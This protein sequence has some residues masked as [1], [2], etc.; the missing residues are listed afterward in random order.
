MIPASLL[1]HLWQSTLFAVAVGLLTLALRK[2]PA[3]VRYWLWFAASCKFLVPFSLLVTIGSLFDRRAGPVNS[4]L[5]LSAVMDQIGRPFA[6]EAP[7]LLATV[8]RTVSWGPVILFGAWLC[9]F[10]IVVFAWARQWQRVRT[11]VRT[12]SPLHLDLSIHAVSSR[13]HL[14][15]GVFGIFRPVL[16]MPEGIT[17]R[18]TPAQW[19][20]ILTHEL[21][22]VR[23]RDNL[24]AAIHMAIEAIFWFHPLV[25][26]IGKRLIDER[27]RACDEEVLLAA[28]D[29]EVYAEGLLNVCRI[30]LE[31]PLACVSGVTGSNLRKRVSAIMTQRQADKL[32]SGRKLLLAAAGLVAIGGPILFGLADAP[33]G[34]AQ[35]Q[36]AVGSR[37]VFDA[38]SI[39]PNTTTNSPGWTRFEPAGINIQR[40]S[41][42]SLISTAYRIPG[43]LVSADPR[44][45][46]LFAA[47]YDIIAKAEHEV[48]KDQLAL[49]LQTLLADR[50]KLT[51]HREN[52]LQPVYKL[53]IA[54][55]GPKLRESQGPQTRD[56]NCAPPK[57][58][59]FN[60]TDIWSFAAVL[61]DRMGRPVLDLT[62]LQ[63]SWDFTLRLDT[64]RLTNDDPGQKTNISDWSLSSIFTDI[65]KQLGLKLESDKA[66][67]ETLVIDHID[68]P[69]EN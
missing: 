60:N 51:L 43:S 38:A 56:P 17:D 6:F 36:V 25:W 3:P 5:P 19:K 22:H 32:G 9:G 35:S 47:R 21:C 16:L 7:A 63:G 31:S 24:T 52:K 65:E 67:V 54:K 49:M 61:A 2:N 53:V 12:A 27:E 1:N 45:R 62:G 68:R 40:A 28:G 18:L 69:S 48:P 59:A 10:L 44:M 64:D 55:G 50:F 8:P 42:A 29:P 39:K 14:E 58:M 13:A 34:K 66:P 23:R 15:P 57:C 33:Q 41:V 37:P 4:P 30:Y 11:A 46:D 20:T 26:W